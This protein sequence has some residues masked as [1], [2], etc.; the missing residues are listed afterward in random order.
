MYIQVFN[1]Y[2]KCLCTY[3][4]WKFCAVRDSDRF[5]LVAD[6]DMHFIAVVQCSVM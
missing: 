3:L 6:C 1:F 2:F 4:M 5:L